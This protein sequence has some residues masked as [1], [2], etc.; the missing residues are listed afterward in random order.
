MLACMYV[1]V[2]TLNLKCA[3]INFELINF[4]L[5]NFE[6]INFETNR[7]FLPDFYDA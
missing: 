3:L 4:E 5:I 6:L 2:R 7:I 1:R